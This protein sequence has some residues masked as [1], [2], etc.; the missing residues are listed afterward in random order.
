MLRL[1]L[2]LT[3]G[4]SAAALTAMAADK[5]ETIKGSITCAKCDLGIEKKCATVVKAGDKVYFLDAAAHKKN[6]TTVCQA[7]KD[8]EVTGVVKKDGDKQVITVSK[9]EFKK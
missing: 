4:A 8:G 7:A 3:L 6:H 2:T 9:V 5:E 1:I